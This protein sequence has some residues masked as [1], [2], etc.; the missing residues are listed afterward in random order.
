VL[1]RYAGPGITL[2]IGL[3]FEIAGWTNEVVGLAFIGT[4]VLWGLI[5]SP[6]RPVGFQVLVSSGARGARGSRFR[7]DVQKLK[8]DDGSAEKRRNWLETFTHT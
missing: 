4:G 6:P 7:F 8:D 5:A 2:L 1:R 3:G